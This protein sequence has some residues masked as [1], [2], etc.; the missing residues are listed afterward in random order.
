MIVGHGTAGT[1]QLRS[2][3]IAGVGVQWLFQSMGGESQRL[4]SRRHLQGLKIQFGNRRRA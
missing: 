4:A 3:M 2:H 1:G